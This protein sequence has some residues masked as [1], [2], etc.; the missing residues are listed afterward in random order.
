MEVP[1][2]FT[3]AAFYWSEQVTR[4]NASVI[5]WLGLHT[6][7]VEGVGSIP[8]PSWGTGILQAAR[9]GQ[10]KDKAIPEEGDGLLQGGRVAENL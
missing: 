2:L 3:S 10:K 4:E 6:F 7:T 1:T 8:A 9:C 5:Q